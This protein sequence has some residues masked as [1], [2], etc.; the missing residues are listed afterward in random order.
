MTSVT[1]TGTGTRNKASSI[2]AL[3]PFKRRAVIVL[4]YVGGRR[5]PPSGEFGAAAYWIYALN[6]SVQKSNTL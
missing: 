1:H 6:Q 4:L 5:A 2:I 3:C